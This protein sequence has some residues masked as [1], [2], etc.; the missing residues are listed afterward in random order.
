MSI[1]ASSSSSSTGTVTTSHHSNIFAEK[2][3]SG[4]ISSWLLQ[5][6][7]CAAA[8]NWNDAEKLKKLPAFLRGRAATHFYALTPDQKG[9][10]DTLAVSLKDSLCP[11]VEREKY[12]A[13][14]EQRKLRPGEDPAVYNWESQQL[15]SKANPTLAGEASTALL[16]RQF[17]KGLPPQIKLKL[18]EHDPVPKLQTMVQFVQRY[19]A[20]EVQM[21]GSAVEANNVNNKQTSMKA[22]IAELAAAVKELATEQKQLRNELSKQAETERQT[23]PFTNSCFKC[24]RRGHFARECRS[25]PTNQGQ[26]NFRGRSDNDHNRTQSSR[27]LQN[28][29][30][31]IC[32]QFGHLARQCT[33][34]KHLNE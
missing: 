6:N 22:E 26:G 1:E 20:V 21:S 28:V 15:L 7:T 27:S 16:E 29:Q 34:R 24:G 13:K 31:F 19:R 30:C 25:R 9:D 17:M 23:K 3:D 18:L 5:F 10:Y 4:D 8:N 2:F 11:Q 14:F 32:Y 33:V 12:F